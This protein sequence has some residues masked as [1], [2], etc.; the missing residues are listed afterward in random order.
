M[1]LYH[2]LLCFIFLK[3]RIKCKENTKN[4]VANC[5]DGPQVGGLGLLRNA[6]GNLTLVSP[7]SQ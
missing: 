4:M 1:L 7:V 3:I 2:H 5:R 6:S